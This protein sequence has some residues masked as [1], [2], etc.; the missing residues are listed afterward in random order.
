MSEKVDKVVLDHVALAQMVSELRFVVMRELGWTGLN[1]VAAPPEIHSL[2]KVNTVIAT[3]RGLVPYFLNLGIGLNPTHPR[4]AS[5]K[6]SMTPLRGNGIRH[7]PS[8]FPHPPFIPPVLP[9]PN[10]N[11]GFGTL[12]GS[13]GSSRDNQ[14]GV[15]PTHSSNPMAKFTPEIPIESF[16]K[17]LL[18][19]PVVI[20]ER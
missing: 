10:H 1:H 3:S 8:S 14:F 5:G 18:R 7:V 13:W 19:R 20:L 11:L 4:E 2:G 16:S 9:Y 15:F 12:L 6:A 17:G